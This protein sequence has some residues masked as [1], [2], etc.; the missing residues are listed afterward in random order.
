MAWKEAPMLNK[1]AFIL[2]TLI[3]VTGVLYPLFF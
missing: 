3:I 2:L 1:A